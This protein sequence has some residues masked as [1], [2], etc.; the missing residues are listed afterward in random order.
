MLNHFPDW[1]WLVLKCLKE[2]H[3]L[4]S[5]KVIKSP[6]FVADAIPPSYYSL[7]FRIVRFD[8]SAMEKNASNLV[9]AEFRV[10]RLQNSKARVSEQRIELYQVWGTSHTSAPHLTAAHPS[11]RQSKPWGEE[12][13][14]PLSKAAFYFSAFPRKDFTQ[15]HMKCVNFF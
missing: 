12:V 2:Q 1:G 11:S 15:N 6:C 3:I 9:K 14:S 7:Y 4:S 13:E 10:F 5:R 8:V